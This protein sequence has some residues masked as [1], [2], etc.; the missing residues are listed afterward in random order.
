M[1]VEFFF[2]VARFEEVIGIKIH[3]RAVQKNVT[4]MKYSFAIP[5]CARRVIWTKYPK[6]K[7]GR[8]G[9]RIWKCSQQYPHVVIK[10][11]NF[12]ISC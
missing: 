8:N 4:L 11:S 2:F 1:R 3:D 7:L 9:L 6:Y 5:S 12:V 10:N